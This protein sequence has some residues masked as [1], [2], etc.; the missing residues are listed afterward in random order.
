MV[1][2]NISFSIPLSGN[3]LK[4]SK[5]VTAK[6]KKKFLINFID[7]KK[8][9]PHINLFS[10]STNRPEAIIKTMKK[11]IKPVFNE[12]IKLLGFGS[13]LSR[14]PTIFL[15]FESSDFLKYLRDVIFHRSNLWKNID[16][17]VKDNIWIPKSTLVHSDMKVNQMS[18][19][20]KFLNSLVVPQI[21]KIEEISLIDFTKKEFE[22]DNFN[23]KKIK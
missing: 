1:K 17:G 3:T 13:F 15:R 10:G 5:E 6:L 18:E 19:V 20:V 23:I 8:S 12:R 2:K 9:R 22:I 14:F 4:F 16:I 7:N 11:K 21:M